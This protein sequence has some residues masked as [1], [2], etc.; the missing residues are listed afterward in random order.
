MSRSTVLLAGA[1]LYNFVE[2]NFTPEM[3]VWGN[4][5][6]KIGEVALNSLSEPERGFNSM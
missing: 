2:A 5:S 3:G 1:S 4:H 6:P